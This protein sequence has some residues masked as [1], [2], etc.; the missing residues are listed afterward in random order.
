MIPTGGCALRNLLAGEDPVGTATP[1]D[2]LFLLQIPPPW[3]R[4]AAATPGV[5]REVR[6]ALAEAAAR[7]LTAHALL[8]DGGETPPEGGLRLLHFARPAGAAKR[9]VRAS[10]T[11]P[12]DAVATTMAG[13]VRGEGATPAGVAREA[14][15]RPVRDLLVC[16]HGE[17]DDCCGRYGEAAYRYLR[18]RHAGP[19][20]HVW[21]VSHFGGHR[22]APTLVDLPD[23]RCWGRL[24]EEA[25]DA[26]VRRS[27]DPRELASCY[28]GWHALPAAA[29][30]PERDLFFA[31]GWSWREAEVEAVVEETSDAGSLE[32]ALRY[33]RSDGPFERATARLAPVSGVAVQASCG[34]EEHPR[35]RYATRWTEAPS[36]SPSDASTA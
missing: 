26:I 28:R 17:R 1:F 4:I 9:Y 21:R 20:L 2:H 36:P 27:G 19:A 31:H 15:E 23:G 11:T 10:Y 3:E 14:A 18:D 24:S 13:I 16:T 29:Q 6:E 22:F 34:A 8:V 32:V 33:R 12:A 7:G 35:P 25:C 30:V 5:P